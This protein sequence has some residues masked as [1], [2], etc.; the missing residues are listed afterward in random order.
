M[1]AF[2]RGAIF[3]LRMGQLWPVEGRQVSWAAG[4]VQTSESR[5]QCLRLSL[6]GVS[7]SGTQQLAPHACCLL[8]LMAS[9]DARMKT[10]VWLETM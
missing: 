10:A 2:L 7:R 8:V 5:G 9:V 6:R 3:C 4:P 1:V